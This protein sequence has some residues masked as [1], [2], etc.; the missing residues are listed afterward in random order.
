MDENIKEKDTAQ[1]GNEELDL[2]KAIAAAKE[3]KAKLIAKNMASSSFEDEVIQDN[4]K[5]VRTDSALQKVK[6]AVNA[7]DSGNDRAGTR[8]T[9]SFP[10]QNGSDTDMERRPGGSQG[11][12]RPPQNGQ[13]RP[14]GSRRPDSTRRADTTRRPSGAKRRPVKKKK[15]VVL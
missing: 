15:K 8:R 14:D 13:R 2:E 11:R 6:D 9:A 1:Q 5:Q 3:E 12:R 7:V 10:A 4:G